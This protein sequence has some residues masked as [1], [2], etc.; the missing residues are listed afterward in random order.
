MLGISSTKLD[1][2]INK[3][4]LSIN[5]NVFSYVFNFN[6][7]FPP[8]LRRNLLNLKNTTKFFPTQC[9]V[10]DLELY[11]DDI[12]DLL[13]NPTFYDNSF[14]DNNYQSNY[15]P[16]T[17]MQQPQVVP[18]HYDVKYS[19]PM[20]QYIQTAPVDGQYPPNVNSTPPYYF[21][22][23]NHSLNVD[24][25]IYSSSNDSFM[26]PLDEDFRNNFNNREHDVLVKREIELSSDLNSEFSVD[27]DSKYA[28]PS[29]SHTTMIHSPRSSI[30]KLDKDQENPKKRKSSSL[31][32]ITKKMK[33][34]SETLKFECSFCSARF[35]VKSYL[36][37]HLK[38]HQTFKAFKC[39]FYHENPDANGKGT[40]C[41]PTG[42]FS[43]RDTYKTHLK[44]LHFIYPPCTKST[45]RSMM[46]GRCAGC[47]AHFDNNVEWLE[48]HIEK[49]KCSGALII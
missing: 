2:F 39:P 4:L 36:T 15:V 20:V 16:V 6:V 5:I 3:N 47:F 38:K 37:R 1:G 14:H 11:N 33:E 41:H 28:T 44:A 7:L 34:D 19:N 21:N 45:E 18:H 35:R 31:I 13:N 42:G 17:M 27:F 46:G 24:L 9:A 12:Y 22:D 30:V 40:K 23:F 8:I 26:S 48:N 49:G 29:V 25:D 43:R 10:D 32:P